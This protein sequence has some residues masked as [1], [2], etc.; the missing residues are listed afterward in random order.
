MACFNPVTAY[1]SNNGESAVTFKPNKSI[2]QTKIKLPCNGCIGCRLSY[3][4]QWALRI[5]H[6]AKQYSKNCFITLTYDD[7]QLPSDQSLNVKHFQKFIKRLRKKYSNRTIRY[8]HCGEY[9]DLN[10]RPHYHAC[11]FNLDFED[12]EIFSSQNGYKTYS[13]KT[14]ENLWGKGFTITADLTQLSAE[15]TARY[16]LKKVTGDAAKEHYQRIDQSTGEVIQLKPEYTTM[17]RRPG[18]GHAFYQQYK[19]DIY[20]SDEIID[21]HFNKVPIPKYYDRLLQKEQPEILEH[22]K[23]E[24]KQKSKPFRKDQTKERL[25]TREKCVLARL[26]QQKREL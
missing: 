16:V 9:G 20:P 8:F 1:Q 5:M 26:K 2:S 19:N 22:I 24:R 18:V 14:L 21:N 3:S 13:S 23:E 17:S 7:E 4:K 25:N 6:E 10:N 12:K 15:Y 11:I